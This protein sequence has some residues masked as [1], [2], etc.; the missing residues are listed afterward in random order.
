MSLETDRKCKGCGA[1]VAFIESAVSRQLMILDPEPVPHGNIIVR[2]G[3]AVVLKKCDL[4]TPDDEPVKLGEPRYLDH[5]ATCPN[6]DQFRRP[7][8]SK[9][10]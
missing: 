9:G 5:H 1:P 4:F 10:A 7:K 3:K 2:E 6:R 8:K